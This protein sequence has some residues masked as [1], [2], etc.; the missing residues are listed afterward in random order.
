MR[1]LLFSRVRQEDDRKIIKNSPFSVYS[2]CPLCKFFFFVT[3]RSTED[4][5]R[6]TEEDME[7]ILNHEQ[8]DSISSIVLGIGFPRTLCPFSVIRTLSSIRIPPIDIYFS[9]LL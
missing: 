9:I 1:A 4:S 7:P 2:P 6:V 8:I 3:Q 5:Q